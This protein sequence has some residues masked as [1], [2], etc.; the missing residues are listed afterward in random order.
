MDQQ[1]SGSSLAT[2]VTRFITLEFFPVEI[3]ENIVHKVRN[4]DLQ[5]LKAGIRKAVFTVTHNV[6]QNA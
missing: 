3:C 5:Q 6:L 1:R 2:K 4:H